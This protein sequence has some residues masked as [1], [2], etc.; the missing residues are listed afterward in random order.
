[1]GESLLQQQLDEVRALLARLCEGP[2]SGAALSRELGIT[3]SAVWKRIE[4]LRM[5]H[6][7]E[8]MAP[9]P[10]G[11]GATAALVDSFAV[12]GAPPRDPTAPEVVVLQRRL[13]A[14]LGVGSPAAARASGAP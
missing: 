13:L 5:A 11:A 10:P 9:A 7:V 4:A 8:V 1:M 12:P 3:R 2:A 6:R 14:A